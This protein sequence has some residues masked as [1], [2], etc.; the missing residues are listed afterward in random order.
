MPGIAVLAITDFT[1]IVDRMATIAHKGSGTEGSPPC[2]ASG[3]VQ[4]TYGTCQ[5]AVKTN[6]LED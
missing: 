2:P 3:R 5:S 1:R 6:H 4:A